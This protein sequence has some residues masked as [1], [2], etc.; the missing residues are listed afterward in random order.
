M[1][2]FLFL[3]QTLFISRH[4]VLIKDVQGALR[5]DLC[6]YF[7]FE[8]KCLFLSRETCDFKRGFISVCV[9]ET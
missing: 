4:R 9:T 8:Q 6:Y 3:V 2:T 1:V 5:G 7:N